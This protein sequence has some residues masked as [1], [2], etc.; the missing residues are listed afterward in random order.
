[1]QIANDNLSSNG[2]AIRESAFSVA[3][4]TQGELV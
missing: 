4:L 2:K 1:M 3:E